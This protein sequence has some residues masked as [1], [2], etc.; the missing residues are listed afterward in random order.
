MRMNRRTELYT[1]FHR[2]LKHA[3]YIQNNRFLESGQM[4]V[5]SAHRFM[6]I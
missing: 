3:T 2:I 4:D 6:M 5:D 1:V